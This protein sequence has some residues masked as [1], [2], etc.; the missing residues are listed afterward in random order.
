METVTED[1]TIGD[2]MAVSARPAG[3]GRWPGVV[4]RHGGYGI[5]EVR[6]RQA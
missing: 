6:R 5:N 3:A 2:R 1:V 4:V